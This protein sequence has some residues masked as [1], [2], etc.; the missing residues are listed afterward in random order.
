M[1]SPATVAASNATSASEAGDPAR[2]AAGSGE[3]ARQ[4]APGTQQRTCPR[5]VQNWLSARSGSRPASRGHVVAIAVPPDQRAA[6]AVTGVPCRGRKQPEKNGGGTGGSIAGPQCASG[7]RSEVYAT[8]GTLWVIK[9]G[10]E[11]TGNKRRH[12]GRRL[13][14]NG[15]NGTW[16]Q[17][18]SV[19][20][21][22]L[23]VPP[24]P[25]LR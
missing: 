2:A 22:E 5:C 25:A 8:S 4:P 21:A 9:Y 6:T 12:P 14:R 17:V 24:R 15:K 19:K 23:C 11:T 20:S 16:I 18:M 3:I 10:S 1:T 7:H 13:R